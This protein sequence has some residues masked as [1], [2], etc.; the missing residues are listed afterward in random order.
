MYR[1]IFRHTLIPGKEKEF[2]DDWKKGSD[3]IQTYPG[4]RGTKLFNDLEN[5]DVV[6]AIAEW[7]SKT[8]RDAAMAELEKRP[9]AEMV[10]RGHEKFVSKFEILGSLELIAESNPPQVETERGSG[11]E[12]K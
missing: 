4:A 10:L 6:V 7:D 2:K 11:V 3:I 5:P 12:N 1:I 9:D 8:A